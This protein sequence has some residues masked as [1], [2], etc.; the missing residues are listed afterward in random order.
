MM[1]FKLLGLLNNGLVEAIL[2]LKYTVIDWFSFLT[3]VGIPLVGA[4]FLLGI[5]ILILR[6]MRIAVYG[7]FLG[8]FMNLL[9]FSQDTGN[10]DFSALIHLTWVL[11]FFSFF[12]PL[13]LFMFDRGYRGIVSAVSGMFGKGVIVEILVNLFFFYAGWRIEQLL[14]YL[15]NIIENIIYF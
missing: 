11:I 8:L 14:I 4:V 12:V 15:S 9:Q 5:I 7:F 10:Y 13:F 2:Q 3:N 1:N 6:Y